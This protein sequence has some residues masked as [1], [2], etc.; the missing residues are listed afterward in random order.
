MTR[1][2]SALLIK[3]SYPVADFSISNMFPMLGENVVL[4]NLSK[5]GDLFKWTLS[6]DGQ[7]TT[8]VTTVDANVALATFD[9][10][11]QILEVTNSSGV[12]QVVKPIYGLLQPSEAYCTF[13]TQSKVLHADENCILTITNL[14]SYAGDFTM[15]LVVTKHDTGEVVL[16]EPVTDMVHSFNIS[17]RGIYDLE[18]QTTTISNGKIVKYRSVFGL[19]VTPSLGDISAAIIHE[20]HPVD[21]EFNKNLY[22]L[23]YSQIYGNNYNFSGRVIAPGTVIVLKKPSDNYPENSTYRVRLDNVVG[24]KEQPVI[25]TIEDDLEI[26]MSSYWGIY[27][28]GSQ[29]VIID[30][31]GFANRE[32]GLHIYKHP[33]SETGLI[34]VAIGNKSSYIELHSTEISKVSFCGIQA[35]TDPTAS[36]PSAW[37]GN[38]SMEDL[39]IHDNYIHET[40]G[41]GMYLG[42]FSMGIKTGTVDG[43][44]VTYRPHEM[45]NTK[46]YNNRLVRC[47]WDS[48]Q[49]NNATESEIACNY[50]EDSAWHGEPNQA[51]CMSLGFQ[52]KIYNNNMVGNGHGLGI[53]IGFLGETWIFNNVFNGHSHGSVPLFLLSQTDVPE[54]N[55]NEDGRNTIPIHVFNN[56]MISHESAPIIS[57]Q[58]VCQYLGLDIYNNLYHCLIN[59][60]FQGQSTTTI[61]EWHNNARNNINIFNSEIDYKIAGSQD[62]NFNIYPDSELATAGIVDEFMHDMRGFYNWNDATKFVGSHAGY[63]M[64][65]DAALTLLTFTIQDGQAQ[66][67]TRGIFVSYTSKGSPTHYLISEDPA[68]GD[69]TWQSITSQIPFALSPGEGL[70]TLYFKLKNDVVETDVLSGE[71][72]YSEMMQYLVNL[73]VANTAYDYKSAPWNNWRRTADWAGMLFSGLKNQYSIESHLSLDIVSQFDG[74][75]SNYNSAIADYP[76]PAGVV[77]FKWKILKDGSVTGIGT[78]KLAGCLLNKRYDILMYAKRMSG[79]VI[80]YEINNGTEIIS[81]LYNYGYDDGSVSGY[82]NVCAFNNITPSD[83]GEIFISVS[84]AAGYTVTDG[85]QLSLLDIREHD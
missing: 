25:V 15:Q 20:V 40:A 22:G 81:Q 7:T 16:T 72:E 49:L 68:F 44:T 80:Q 82:N 10:V 17:V 26:E 57:A 2:N 59:N 54:Q 51:T 9:R 48:I 64:L 85:A 11:N 1:F 18:L 60:I 24:T 33:E 43:Q 30:G 45:H 27:V 79:G 63:V 66:T 6:G 67:N 74:D 28:G 52:G 12:V 5:H 75:D 29:H 38:F 55:P 39:F 32:H 62:N 71:I 58:N 70:K 31:R 42:Y 61:A 69:A 84:P 23:P 83:Q 53:Q 65:S 37:R 14:F 8:E 3:Q 4:T 35:K 78:I 21:S 13:E 47:G 34:A 73:T 56:T 50:I 36:D 46:V 77:R 41:E 19:T 76:Y